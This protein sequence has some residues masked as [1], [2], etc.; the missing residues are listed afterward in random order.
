MPGSGVEEFLFDVDAKHVDAALQPLCIGG[1][2]GRRNMDIFWFLPMLL[3]AIISIWIFY[4][5]VMREG[6]SGR[7]TTGK[8]LFDKPGRE[9]DNLP[10]P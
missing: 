6:G 5:K 7:R 9:P 2:K 4:R 10:P 1:A 3:A 8:V